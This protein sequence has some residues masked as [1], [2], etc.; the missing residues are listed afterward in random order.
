MKAG[1]G[2]IALLALTALAG[3]GKVGPLEPRTGSSGPAKALGQSEVPDAETLLKPSVQARPGRSDELMRRSEKR[4]EDPFDLPPVSEAPE[5]QTQ[6]AADSANSTPKD[7][8]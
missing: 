4:N 3:C 6:S 2:M 7:R 8:N 1:H 5:E